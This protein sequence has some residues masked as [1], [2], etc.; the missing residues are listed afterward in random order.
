MTKTKIKALMEKIRDVI[1]DDTAHP[2]LIILVLFCIRILIL[3]LSPTSLNDL[4]RNIWPVLLTLLV[5]FFFVYKKIRYKFLIKN[6][7]QNYNQK[8][9]YQL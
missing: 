7:K 5:S 2:S 9:F 3:R 8:L 1:K 6:V 4:F